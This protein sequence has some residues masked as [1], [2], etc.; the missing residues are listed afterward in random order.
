MWMST[1]ATNSMGSMSCVPS[2]RLRRLGYRRCF[3]K[4]REGRKADAV[5]GS[6][7]PRVV[8]GFGHQLVGVVPGHPGYRIRRG[9]V[10]VSLQLGKVFEGIHVG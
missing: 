9:L 2:A 7:L 3:P 6:G 8:V 4:I 5:K 1:R 10:G